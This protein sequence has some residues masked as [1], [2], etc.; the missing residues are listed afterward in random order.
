RRE[1]LPAEWLLYPRMVDGEL[2]LDRVETREGA[3]ARD[4]LQ[5]PDDAARGALL[6]RE[7]AVELRPL[8]AAVAQQGL[9]RAVRTGDEVDRQRA[10]GTG[11]FL[12]DRSRG[13][14]APEPLAM[15]VLGRMLASPVA[16]QSLE[17][18]ARQAAARVGDCDTAALAGFWLANR[19]HEQ[20]VV[21]P[22]QTD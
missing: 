6:A 14:R 17:R 11:A 19:L 16:G 1:R 22:L 8:L 4:L 9:L 5:A 20:L 15:A 2:R 10:G 21:G 13:N 12:L 7:S 18:V 3:L